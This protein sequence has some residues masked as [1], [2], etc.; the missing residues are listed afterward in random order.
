MSNQNLG[1]FI[2][3]TY[4]PFSGKATEVEYLIVGGGGSGG[5]GAGAGPCGSAGGGA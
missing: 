3:A 5:D 4:D 2:S 1:G